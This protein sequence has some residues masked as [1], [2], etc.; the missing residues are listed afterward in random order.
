MDPKPAGF[1]GVD[2]DQV[3]A[4]MKSSH[5]TWRHPCRIKEPP[6]LSI[7]VDQGTNFIAG[8]G[9]NL[10]TCILFLSIPNLARTVL[11]E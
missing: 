1:D 5:R 4:D 2:V 8:K 11:D 6:R 10:L 3:G 7:L 9:W